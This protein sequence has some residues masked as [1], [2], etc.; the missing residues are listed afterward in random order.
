M[1]RPALAVYAAGVAAILG[2]FVYSLLPPDRDG[3]ARREVQRYLGSVTTRSVDVK[4]CR[5]ADDPG[6]SEV[7]SHY[8][9]RVTARAPIHVGPARIRAGSA[10][11]CFEVPRVPQPGPFSERFHDADPRFIS[12]AAPTVPRC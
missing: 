8:A 2:Y 9:C 5:Y 12:A 6:E 11:Y 10:D 1:S 4:G 3:R 7:L